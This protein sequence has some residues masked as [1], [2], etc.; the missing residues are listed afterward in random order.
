MEH[1]RISF[2][3]VLGNYLTNNMIDKG[4]HDYGRYRKKVEYN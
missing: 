4:M 2:K 1:V 3:L